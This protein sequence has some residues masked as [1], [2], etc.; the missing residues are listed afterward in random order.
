MGSQQP[1]ERVRNARY[2]AFALEHLG[3]NLHFSKSPQW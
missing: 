2:Q 3:Q 1:W